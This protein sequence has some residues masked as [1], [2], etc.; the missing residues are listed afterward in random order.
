MDEERPRKERR[1]RRRFTDEYKAATVKLVLS[2]RKT[3][4][5]VARDLDLTETA[6]RH[7]VRQA[8]ADAGK[9]PVGVVTTAEKEELAKL[10]KEVRELRME[11]EILVKAA[12]FF[13]KHQ[14]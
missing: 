8:Q 13:A 14:S 5:Q 12:A 2:G 11:R 6:V 3:A 9:G 10:R 4:G 1:K 7:W